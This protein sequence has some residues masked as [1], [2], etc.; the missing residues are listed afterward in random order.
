MKERIKTIALVANVVLMMVL[1][2]FSI[3]VSVEM[4][5]NTGPFYTISRW[6]RGE[7]AP[8]QEVTRT[9]APTEYPIRMVAVE[10]GE[11]LAVYYQRGELE[12]Q[13][14]GL[15]TSFDE[16]LSTAQEPR[17]ISEQEYRGLVMGSRGFL[18]D[19]DADLPLYALRVW[20][21]APEAEGFDQT[22]SQLALTVS[23]DGVALAFR[24]G[25]AY[26]RC[27]T[28]AN[29]AAVIANLENCNTSEDIV[30]AGNLGGPGEPYLALAPEEVVENDLI[31]LSSYD[32]RVPS[33]IAATDNTTLEL[34]KC[35]SMN[36]YMENHYQSEEGVTYGQGN[37]VLSLHKN[38][39]LHFSV[40][41]G[42]GLKAEG[43]GSGT[44]QQAVGLIDRARTAVEGVLKLAG[45]NWGLSLRGITP[46]NEEGNYTIVFGYTVDGV[47]LGSGG[48]DAVVVQVEN[49]RIIALKMTV[50][51]L[52]PTD[53]V[54]LLPYRQAVAALDVPPGGGLRLTP[55]YSRTVGRLTPYLS[56]TVQEGAKA[57]GMEKG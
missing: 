49:G 11:G 21:G 53:E 52:T 27:T 29:A 41:G 7:T 5:E 16:A 47:P 39:Q 31:T 48:R 8:R 2:G 50:M 20:A 22:L 24:G 14:D 18:F 34:L 46:L 36:P 40:T 45:G 4:S 35:F 12:A 56:Y 6:L 15:R 32:A 42:D 44:R 26:Y 25:S 9:E 10:P 17:I 3:L 23:E 43:S 54:T 57:D 30:F 51:T 37:Y 13:F 19:Y 33:F 38:G 1:F 28:M 55:R